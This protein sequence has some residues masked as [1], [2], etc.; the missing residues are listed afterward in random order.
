MDGQMGPEVPRTPSYLCLPRTLENSYTTTLGLTSSFSK[1]LAQFR[2][3]R[4]CPL[5]LVNLAEAPGLRK[6]C[7]NQPNNG[8]R[9]KQQTQALQGEWVLG[10]TCLESADIP[11]RQ[12]QDSSLPMGAL[13]RRPVLGRLHIPWKQP[14]GEDRRKSRSLA[15][16]LTSRGLAITG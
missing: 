1:C 2:A 13:A 10:P 14:A 15:P 11:A 7:D 9:L 6:P 4:R 8:G 12:A 3:H 5:I 16:H